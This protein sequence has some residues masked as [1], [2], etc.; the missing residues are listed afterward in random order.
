MMIYF[1]SSLH[2]EVKKRDVASRNQSSSAR[3]AVNHVPSRDRDADVLARHAV[4][5]LGRRPQAARDAINPQILH[6]GVLVIV[7]AGDVDGIA[8]D[9]GTVCEPGFWAVSVHKLRTLKDPS[10]VRVSEKKSFVGPPAE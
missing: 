3:P 6:L 5:D 7:A 9:K 1:W 8:L 10:S 2:R 4:F